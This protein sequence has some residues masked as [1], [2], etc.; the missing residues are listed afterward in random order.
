MEGSSSLSAYLQ[1]LCH[2]TQ[3]LKQKREN[4]CFKFR[5]ETKQ[6]MHTI[7]TLRK[8]IHDCEQQLAELKKELAEAEK[9]ASALDEVS[10]ILPLQLSEYGRYGRQM[11]LDGFG[12]PCVC[13]SYG[14]L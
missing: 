3:A 9:R 10:Q 1:R 2:R 12:L 7:V 6:G 8:R 14:E 13:L 4:I 5:L 11:I